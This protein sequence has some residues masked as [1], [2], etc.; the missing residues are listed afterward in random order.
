MSAHE[1][2]S[3]SPLIFRGFSSLEVGR[4]GGEKT[5]FGHPSFFHREDGRTGK[6]DYLPNLQESLSER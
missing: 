3:F 5:R 1:R 2:F 4:G 6:G